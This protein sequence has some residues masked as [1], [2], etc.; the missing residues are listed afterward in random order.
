ET[1]VRGL[2]AALETN[3]AV[4]SALATTVFNG[5]P[6]DHYRTVAG[7]I[8]KITRGD[9]TRVARKWIRPR[10][11]PVVVVGPV[12]GA[13]DALQALALGEV[14]LHTAP[15]VLEVRAR[16]PQA[17]AGAQ[18]PTAGTVHAPD[19]PTG[20]PEGTAPPQEPGPVARPPAPSLP[21]ASPP[22]PGTP[23]PTRP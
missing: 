5:L 13:A 17:P 11:W 21:G 18:G 3:D 9:A 16:A 12:G 7:R 15:G 19:V 23:P 6:R 14:R 10:Q 1:L 20:R 8:E 2:P 22:G 4:A